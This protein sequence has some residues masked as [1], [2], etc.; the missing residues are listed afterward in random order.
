MRR[1]TVST[2]K[3]QK[4]NHWRWWHVGSFEHNKVLQEKSSKA[5]QLD[6]KIQQLVWLLSYLCQT[7]E[8]V[9]LNE[10]ATYLTK[11]LKEKN[12]SQFKQELIILGKTEAEID[13]WFVFSDVSIKNED[14]KIRS[15][16]G[17]QFHT[18]ISPLDTPVQSTG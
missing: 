9:P 8:G 12:K 13:L 15:G 6:S 16:D 17:L 5:I 18:R 3:N 7:T 10:L 14:P 4:C 11:N 1:S 2:K